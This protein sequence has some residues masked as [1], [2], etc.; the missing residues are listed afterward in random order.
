MASLKHLH[1]KKMIKITRNVRKKDDRKLRTR[2]T[3]KLNTKK[4]G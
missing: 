2:V 4:K 3:K 1:Q